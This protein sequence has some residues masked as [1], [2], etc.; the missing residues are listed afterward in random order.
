MIKA[1]KNGQLMNDQ[2]E[3]QNISQI[4]K[5]GYKNL[6]LLEF[7]EFNMTAIDPLYMFFI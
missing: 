6:P 1:K 4:K 2:S 7:I 3:K 5:G